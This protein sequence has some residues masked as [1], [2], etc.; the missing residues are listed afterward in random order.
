MRYAGNK[1]A[2]PDTLLHLQHAPQWLRRS[3]LFKSSPEALHVCER[4]ML[5]Y[6]CCIPMKDR[7]ACKTF[8]I[9]ISASK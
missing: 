4:H 1:G 8:R 7:R 5:E 2:I 6:M 3:V 9:L